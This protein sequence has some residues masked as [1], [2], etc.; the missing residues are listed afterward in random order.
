MTPRFFFSGLIAAATCAAVHVFAAPACTTLHFE[1][2]YQNL[3]EHAF[4]LKIVEAEVGMREAERWQAGRRPNPLVNFEYGG[5]GNTNWDQN[6]LFLEMTQLLELGGK[7][8]ARE[9]VATA[10]Q[11][12]T[13][14]DIDIVKCDLYGALLNAF[15]DVAI[16]QERVAVA[17]DLLKT[18]DEGLSST[19]QKAQN[20][21]GSAVDIKKAEIAHRMAA[22]AQARRRAELAQAKVRLSSLWDEEAPHFDSVAFPVYELTPPP[23]LPQLATELES[24][25]ILSK[26]YAELQKAWEAVSLE[27]ARRIPDLAVKVGV[28][29]EHFCKEPSLFLGIEIPLPIF[30][31]NQGNIC[32]AEHER[33]QLL[34]KQLNIASQLNSKLELVH[35]AWCSAYEQAIVLKE[36]VETAALQSYQLAHD[37]Y[38]A[39]KVEYLALLDA[40]AT[41][42]GLK[43]QY[44]DAL[45]ECHHRRVDTLRLTTKCCPALL[46][47][48]KSD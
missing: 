41:L 24:N 34:F 45:E 12:A 1:S 18:A 37:S 39:G 44:L 23:A 40:R 20:G 3:L 21:K 17:E 26:S 48:Q 4:E 28:N 11:A 43:M 42:F 15:V 36:L 35:Q 27:R 47:Q 32:R 13:S 8:R 33:N 10:A 29:T 22:L 5:S 7:R 16:A 14:W 31:R 9:R 2:A 25:P 46:D 30:D 6:Q 38:H 19:Q